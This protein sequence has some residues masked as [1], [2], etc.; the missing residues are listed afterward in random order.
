MPDINADVGLRIQALNPMRQPLGGTVDIE[1][2]PSGSGPA[3]NIKAADASKDID[4]TGLQR[5]PQI[6]YRVTVTPTDVSVPVSQ[7]LTV[8]SSGFVTIQF[9]IDKTGMAAIPSPL[10][11]TPVKTASIVI[12]PV[13]PVFPVPLP[14][15]PVP[16]VPPTP[17]V[18]TP[19]PTPIPPPTPTPV[20]AI[21]D[22]FTQSA[23]PAALAPRLAGT[24]ANGV[25]GASSTSTPPTSVIWVDGCNEVLVHL[26]S[27]QASILAGIIVLSVDLETDQ[28]G[29]TPLICAY[30]VNDGND[31]VG[32]LAATDEFPRGDGRLAATWGQQV[33]EALWSSILSLS[34]DHAAERNL[35]PRGFT[36]TPGTLTLVAGNPI[37]VKLV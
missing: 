20:Y 29:R 11:T 8:P 27:L 6:S 4:I 31:Q 23:L 5:T 34:N 2:R 30:A 10:P 25:T 19:T 32:L 18:P 13:P 33:Q 1:L 12:H 28:T 15:A 17:P 35:A 7:S 24:P 22:T 16:P 14:I 21:P 3:L 36:A 26:D 37:A 9:V